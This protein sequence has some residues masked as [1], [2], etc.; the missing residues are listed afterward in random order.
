MSDAEAGALNLRWTY[1]FNK[2]AIGAVH[3]LAT[4]SRNA[5][6][7]PAGHTGVIYNYERRTQKLLQGHSNT[8]KCCCVTRDKRFIATADAGDESLIVIWDSTTGVPV[9]TIFDPHPNGI[10]AMDFSFDATY[11]VTLSA[12]DPS[13]ETGQVVAIWEWTSAQTD[14]LCTANVDPGCEQHC[15]KVNPRNEYDIVTNG[16]STVFFWSWESGGLTSYQP[17]LSARDFQQSVAAYTTSTFIGADSAVTGT[18][19]GDVVQWDVGF[20]EQPDG[21]GAAA[22]PAVQPRSALKIIR[23]GEGHSIN[24]LA[25][26]DDYI[27]CGTADGAVRFYDLRFRIIAWFEDLNAGSVTSVSF[28][29]NRPNH[30]ADNNPDMFSVPD[31]IVGTQLALIVGVEA[32]AFEEV[33]EDNRRGVLLVQGIDSDIKG[34]AAH[35]NKQ[36]FAVTSAAGTLQMWNVEHRA[37]MMVASFMEE[38]VEPSCLAFDPEGRYIA[39]A[40]ANGLLMFLE[41]TKLETLKRYRNTVKGITHVQF[42]PDGVFVAVADSD[43]CVGL[44]RFKEADPV[45]NEGPDWIYLGKNRAHSAPITGL[46]FANSGEGQLLLVS[47]SEDQHLAEFDLETSSVERGVVFKR[48]R[49]RVG[50]TETPTA[51]LWCPVGR[52]GV[53]LDDNV[54]I[55]ATTEFKFELWSTARGECIKT[56]L[57]PA[58]AGPVNQMLMLPHSDSSYLAYATF[59]K[60]IGLVKFPL[61]GNPTSAMGIIAHPGEISAIAAS[62]DGRSL[63]TAGREDMTVAIW[64]VDTAVVD[65]E[66]AASP[67]IDPYLKLLGEPEEE[68][69]EA[70]G[71]TYDEL[72]DYFFYSQLRTQGVSSKEQRKVTGRVPLTEIPN[73]MRALGFYPTQKQIDR[74]IQEVR[75]AGNGSGPHASGLES[76]NN[77][78]GA[79]GGGAGSSVATPATAS[80][81]SRSRRGTQQ[82]GPREVTD[83]NLQDFVKLYVNHRPV[84]GVSNS[85][86][87]AAL[88]T[89]GADDSASGGTLAWSELK[90]RLQNEGEKLS[91]AELNAILGALRGGDAPPKR[92]DAAAFANDVLGFAGDQ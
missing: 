88:D 92:I 77:G 26:V 83:I 27:V 11:L 56:A 59:D 70:G 67:G 36:E 87:A 66:A 78:D 68:G 22:A 58:Y 15:I 89:L 17:K 28:A 82:Q 4:D 74:M 21:P 52:A 14:A 43:Y 50:D 6:F 7:Y 71:E 12:P 60:V 51:C 19:D 80:T 53:P 75:L 63:I 79:N 42:S 38:K 29:A 33:E 30:P 24:Y 8:I 49:F 25:A 37:L 20:A 35:P 81:S 40:F 13:G 3:S 1:G 54:V 69:G 64:D 16:T 45:S 5:L 76:S 34:L 90:F 32:A 39:Q 84:F 86:I 46:Q 65:A 91:D 2:D 18:V 57:A 31:F 85:D 61:D 44:Y 47:A 23:L 55:T 10:V 73:I 72:R 9:K 41:L 62:F 48:D